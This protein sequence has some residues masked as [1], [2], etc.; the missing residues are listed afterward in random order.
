MLIFGFQRIIAVRL[1][2][3]HHHRIFCAKVYGNHTAL[4]DIYQWLIRDEPLPLRKYASDL[5]RTGLCILED[6]PASSIV[7][8]PLRQAVILTAQTCQISLPP[9]LFQFLILFHGEIDR[10]RPWQI[11]QPG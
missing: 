6:L 9:V 1:V 5:T 4:H 7:K 10:L 3:D 8:Y 11:L 2:A